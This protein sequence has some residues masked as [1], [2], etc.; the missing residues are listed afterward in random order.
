[1]IRDSEHKHNR[2][3]VTSVSKYTSAL[4]RLCEFALHNNFCATNPAEQVQFHYTKEP[5]VDRELFTTDDLRKILNG[6]VYQAEKLDGVQ[7]YPY[8]FWIPLLGAF[9]GARLNELCSLNVNDI[10]YDEETKYWYI[11]IND[12][13]PRKKVKT[14]DSKRIIPVHH[15][16][17]EFGFIEYVDQQKRSRKKMLFSD[18][19]TYNPKSGWGDKASKWFNKLEKK[20]NDKYAMGYLARCEVKKPGNTD[21][22]AFHSFRHTFIHNLKNNPDISIDRVADLCGHEKGILQTQSYGGSQYKMPI[23]VDT[24]EKLNYDIDLSHIRYD[25]FNIKLSK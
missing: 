6:H 9:T 15:H 2:L 11:D 4:K 3:A 13:D 24:I 8:H 23:K 21:Q 5:Q 18:G 12:D 25:L 17:I 19:L 20:G 16:L 1:M 7:H 22:K 14:K 10:K